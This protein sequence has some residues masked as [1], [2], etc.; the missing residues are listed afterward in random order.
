[1]KDALESKA[2]QCFLAFLKDSQAV[3]ELKTKLIAYHKKVSMLQKKM[4]DYLFKYDYRLNALEEVWDRI[5]NDLIKEA[6][7][8]K[9]SKKLKSLIPKLTSMS[10]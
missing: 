10:D 1:M 6:L 7:T 2:S 5:K 9:A 8:K 4:K 3:N